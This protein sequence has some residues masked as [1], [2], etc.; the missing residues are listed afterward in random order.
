MRPRLRTYRF[1]GE[2]IASTVDLPLLERSDRFDTACTIERDSTGSLQTVEREWFHHWRIGRQA[3]WLSF[4]RADDG[5]LLRFR[6]L[7]DFFISRDG[8]YIR[9][10]P[11]RELPVDTLRH[12]LLDQVLPLALSRRGRLLLHA[13]AIHVPGVGALAFAGPTGRGKSTLAAALASQGGRILSDDCV[14]IDRQAGVLQ[15]FPAYPGLRLW[16]DGPPRPL[17]RGTIASRVAHYTSKRRVN[18]GVLQFQHQPSPLRALFLVSERSDMGPTVAFRRCRAAA[19]LMGLVRH[20]YLLD[21]EDRDQL[22]RAFEGLSSIATSVPV[23]RLRV[24]HGHGRLGRV[25]GAI[26]AYAQ[27]LEPRPS[28]LAAGTA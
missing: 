3:P 23:L 13:S 28:V 22:V 20:A 27:N 26:R 1:C 14:A 24:R 2:T 11:S 16:L 8:A 12:L 7:A 19:R 18:G 5:Y 10:S 4:A 25:A 15:V 6:Q 21:I 17:P 9:A